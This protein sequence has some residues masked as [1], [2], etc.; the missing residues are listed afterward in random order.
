MSKNQ[1]L[2]VED[3]QTVREALSLL[4]ESNGFQ[5]TQAENGQVALEHLNGARELPDCI[6]LDL[7]MPVMNG[8]TFLEQLEVGPQHLKSIPIVVVSANVAFEKH[9]LLANVEARISKPFLF[10]ELQDVLSVVMS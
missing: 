3:D 5:V 10:K 9:R 8:L 1:I 2:V 4:L 6:I 7:N